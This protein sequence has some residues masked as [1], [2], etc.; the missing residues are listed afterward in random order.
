VWSQSGTRCSCASAG[1]AKPR[2]SG[3]TDADSNAAIIVDASI[4]SAPPAA[5]AAKGAA[6]DAAPSTKATPPADVLI[7][8]GVGCAA[9]V[10]IVCLGFLACWWRSKLPSQ[11][12]GASD[13][14]VSTQPV[15]AQAMHH[16]CPCEGL[17]LPPDCYPNPSRQRLWR[18][19]GSRR[20]GSS[21]PA[22]RTTCPRPPAAAAAGRAGEQRQR[23]PKGRPTLASTAAGRSRR[24]PRA[25]VGAATQPA[26]AGA[27]TLVECMIL[28]GC[29]PGSPT[30]GPAPPA[31][32]PTSA[33]P[34]AAEPRGGEAHAA[35]PR[36]RRV[37][38]AGAG[39]LARVPR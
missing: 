12:V 35:A 34:P 32:A 4:S 27:P 8:A 19:A 28:R 24:A 25:A 11:T 21:H 31:P 15:W 20:R 17:R 29:A 16:T 38:A 23:R 10:V 36:Q 22:G 9:A 13:S 39:L 1:A 26:G 5:S 30:D 7:A 18:C 2:T 3:T 6:G 37:A 14:K 33:C